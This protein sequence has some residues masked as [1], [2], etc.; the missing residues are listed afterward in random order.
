M[1]ERAS[2]RRTCQ[3]HSRWAKTQCS[4]NDRRMRVQ[5]NDSASCTPALS[6]A[7]SR[8]TRVMASMFKPA[9]TCLLRSVCVSA[10]LCDHL[11]SC[12]H[13]RRPAYHVIAPHSILSV[14]AVRSA[15]RT[16]TRICGRLPAGRACVGESLCFGFLLCLL[17]CPTFSRRCTILPWCNHMCYGMFD[18]HT[19][20]CS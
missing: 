13:N 4:S 19:T 18:A 14:L 11:P 1:G 6:R 9:T 20:S 12:L 17:T 8:N 2:R 7:D 15:A 16:C 5:V 10:R 3:A